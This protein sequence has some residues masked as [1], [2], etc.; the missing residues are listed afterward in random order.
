M[1]SLIHHGIQCNACQK[2]PIVGI[3]YNCIQCKSFNLCEACEKKFG[4]KHGHALLKLRNNEQIKIFETKNKL[5]EKEVKLKAK[6]NEKPFCKCVTSKKFKTVN[7]NNFIN[8][9]VTLINETNCNLPLPCFFSCEENLSKIKGNRVKIY[10]VKGE[11]GEKIEFNIKLDLSN[12]KKTGQY[13]S[14]WN[15]KDENG[16]ILSENVIFFVKDI[17][18]DRLQLKPSVIAK[19]FSFV[20]DASKPVKD[21]DYLV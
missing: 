20:L 11:Q 7:N 21:Y 2:Y 19:K 8:I 5:K 9:P 17:F 18:K 4:E 1:E 12:I 13:S 3:R 15:L 10:E 16:N 6:P 14:V